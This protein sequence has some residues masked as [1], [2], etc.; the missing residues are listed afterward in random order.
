MIRKVLP[1]IVLL[2]A[3]SAAAA[4]HGVVSLG[5]AGLEGPGAPIETSSSATLP[6]G[7]F[8]GYVKLDYARFEKYT[9][10][11]DD[12]G[13]FNAFWM[14]GIGY[15]ARPSLSLYLFAPFYTKKSED[16]S[17]NTSGF[18]DLSAMGV[19]GFK[20]DGGLRLIPPKESL[21]DMEDWHFTFYGGLT[22]PTGEA[23]IRSGEGTIDPGMSLGFGKPSYSGGF[24]ATKQ[25]MSRWTW[26]FDTSLIRFVEHEYDDG[27]KTRF[28]D[29][30]RANTAFAVRL[31]TAASRE[32][33]L[34][35]NIEGNYLEL[36]R[37]EADGTGEDATG[38][39][40][41]YAVPG[42]RLYMKNAS[43]GLGVK[44][45]AWTDLNEADDQQGAEGKED[46]RALFTFSVL[47]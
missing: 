41:I 39:A 43:V 7:K 32:L 25:F 34:D 40:M 20:Y 5:V 26:V 28:G 15:G 22:L 9:P 38:G 4:H 16:N 27:R 23:N 6:Q 1:A 47:L 33:R 13:D 37:D 19:F 8:L 10:E 24:T 44:I 46:Y 36:G 18:A 3:A 30:F 42:L 14:Y 35:A 31:L 11:R 12:E 21:D 45:P 29:E 17:Y 2:L